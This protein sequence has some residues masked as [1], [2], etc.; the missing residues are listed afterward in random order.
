MWNDGWAMRFVL[1]ALATILFVCT[2]LLVW[3]AISDIRE[4]NAF[5]FDHNCKV[6]GKMRGDVVTTIAPTTGG[7][8]AIGVASI[9]AK[10][11]WLCDDGITYWR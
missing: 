11:G 8:V 3:A 10:T 1:I 9:P 7:G 4:W 6:V 5:K 2:P